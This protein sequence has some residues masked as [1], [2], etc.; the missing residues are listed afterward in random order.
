[1]TTREA[2]REPGPSCLSLLG[3]IFLLPAHQRRR[4]WPS[5]SLPGILVAARGTPAA[6]IALA[7]LGGLAACVVTLWL[8]IRFTLASPALML[9]KQGVIAVHAPLRQAG[10]G[11]LVA[12]LRHPAARLLLIAARRRSI[13]VSP[14]H[15]HRR[16][17]V[18]GEGVSGLVTGTAPHFGWPFLII[19]GIGSV[20][21]ST[22]TFPITAGVTVLLYID[23]RIRREALD[24]ELARAAGVR[25]TATEP[26]LPGTRTRT[27]S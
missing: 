7:V 9:E 20:I 16:T 8:M 18:D 13:I 25:A 6:G 3:L 14:V 15:P 24:L 12:G 22:I 26:R 4:S 23:Q 21:G 10:P 27:G 19:T 1:M 17:R 5:A 11:R 2:W